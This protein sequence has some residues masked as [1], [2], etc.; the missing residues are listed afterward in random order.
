MNRLISFPFSFSPRILNFS[1]RFYSLSQIYC[2]EVDSFPL[3]TALKEAGEEKEVDKENIVEKTRKEEENINTNKRI[4]D[5]YLN[6]NINS[7]SPRRCLFCCS[8]CYPHICSC[9][10]SSFSNSCKCRIL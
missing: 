10:N 6:N 2:E 1:K 9:S 8:V 7:S 5:K 3:V 4:L